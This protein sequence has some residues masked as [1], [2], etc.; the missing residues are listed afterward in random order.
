MLTW[1][2]S[3]NGF[4]YM[5]TRTL[6]GEP[7]SAPNKLPTGSGGVPLGVIQGVD[8]PSRRSRFPGAGEPGSPGA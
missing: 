7:T 4:R 6:K 8:G 2:D 1:T 5:A 3:V